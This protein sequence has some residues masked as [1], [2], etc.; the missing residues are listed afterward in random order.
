MYER[1]HRSE[2]RRPS[3]RGVE[4]RNRLVEDNTRLVQWFLRCCPCRPRRAV[5]VLGW[6]ECESLCLCALLRAAELWDG[7]GKF[8]GYVCGRKGWFAGTLRRTAKK[9]VELWERELS[10]DEEME[11]ADGCAAVEQATARRWWPL[12]SME[13]R[14]ELRAGLAT[15]TP[16]LAKV[17]RMRYGLPPEGLDKRLSSPGSGCGVTAE[18]RGLFNSLKSCA[19]VL[20]VT[21]ERTRQLVRKAEGQ[22]KDYYNGR[23]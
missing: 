6:Q 17:L 12:R 22:L 13:E 5:W 16:R 8:A 4:E 1:R 3:L 7:V 23:A 2:V 14:E 11:W 19:A 18:V 10:L 20:G 21:L 15:L 9:Q